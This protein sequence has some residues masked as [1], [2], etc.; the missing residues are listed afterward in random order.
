MK[1]DLPYLG[2]IND[3]I[4]AIE[5][6]VAGGRETFLR[7]RMIKMQSSAIPKSSAKLPTACLQRHADPAGAVWQRIIAFRNRL[8]HG[9]WSVD[10]LLVWDVIQKDL[11]GLKLEVARLLRDLGRH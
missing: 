3:A 5:T 6:Y 4:A 7:E 10:L 9:Y 2:H 1:S 8:I 11:P